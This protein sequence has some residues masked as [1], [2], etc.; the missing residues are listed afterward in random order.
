MVEKHEKLK[1]QEKT[2]RMMTNNEKET[3]MMKM[4]RTMKMIEMI[5]ND[6]TIQTVFRK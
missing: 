5:A 6:D 3:N 4:M 1:K 2:I